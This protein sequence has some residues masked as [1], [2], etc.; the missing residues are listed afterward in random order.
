MTRIKI[1]TEYSQNG[2]GRGIK[3]ANIWL[4]DGYAYAKDAK[5]AASDFQPCTG[6][7]TGYVRVN[8]YV[9]N[10]TGRFVQCSTPDFP[11]KDAHIRFVAA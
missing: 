11:S 10:G 2:Y 5:N 6:E 8:H 9:F 3:Q 4:I 7:L 1:G